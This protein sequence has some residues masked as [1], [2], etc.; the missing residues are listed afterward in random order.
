MLIPHVRDTDAWRPGVTDPAP[1]RSRLGLDRERLVLFLGTPR[2]YKGVDDLCSAVARLGRDD[3]ALAVVGADPDGPTARRLRS[4]SS[5]SRCS[6][7]PANTRTNRFR[8]A[9]STVSAA[10]VM[11]R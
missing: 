6:F 5:A 10:A 2:A 4:V 1:A 3:V 11:A 8:P 9:S 7:I